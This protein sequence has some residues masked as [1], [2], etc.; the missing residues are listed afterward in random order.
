[1]HRG[2][3]CELST[4]RRLQIW[5]RQGGVRFTAAGQV[6]D[7]QKVAVDGGW[8]YTLEAPQGA[9]ALVATE[10]GATWRLP[11][12]DAAPSPKLQEARRLRSDRKLSQAKTL[13]RSIQDPAL[14]GGVQGLLGRIALAEGHTKA[15]LQSLE[16]SAAAHARAGRSSDE[17]RARFVLA[18]VFIEDREYASALRVLDPS[19]ACFK[20]NPEDVAGAHY[21]RGLI[22][23]ERGRV[24]PALRALERAQRLGQHLALTSI[25]QSARQT[26]A[27][28]LQQIGR[29]QEAWDIVQAL[30]PQ[31]QG[32]A[33]GHGLVNFAWSLLLA[34]EA[35]VPSTLVP[36]PIL[37]QALQAYL[38]ACPEPERLANVL[39]NRALAHIQAGD[40]VRARADL[41]QARGQLKGLSARLWAWVHDI[42]GRIALAEGRYRSAQDHFETLLENSSESD[43]RWRAG[44]GLAQ[45]LRALGNNESALRVLHQAESEVDRGL[46]WVSWGD[47]RGLFP[48]ARRKSAA[49]LIDL[50]ITMKRPGIA[51]TA[52]RKAR[53]RALRKQ[54]QGGRV[55]ALDPEAL[56]Y[57]SRALGLYRKSQQKLQDFDA[58]MW[59]VPQ[60]AKKQA[61]AER[62][63]LQAESEQAWNTAISLLTLPNLGDPSHLPDL[64]PQEVVLGYHSVPGGWVGFSKFRGRVRGRHLGPWPRSPQK[65]ADYL[66]KPFAE[67]I[68]QASQ[69]RLLTHAQTRAIDFHALTFD[70][71]PLIH[72]RPV[73]YA[74][75]L[76]P[77]STSSMMRALVVSDP[78]GD[79][80]AARQ[81]GLSVAQ[82]L[83]KGGWQVRHILGAEATNATLVAFLDKIDLLHYSG[84]SVFSGIEG[85]H[86]A[87][88][89]AGASTLTAGEILGLARVP[90]RVVLASCEGDAPTQRGGTAGL[91]LARTFVV[92]GASSVVAA[93]RE[94]PD[95]LAAEFVALM[96][97]SE[98]EVA[99][100]VAVQAA[101]RALL[102]R[103]PMAA[104]FRIYVR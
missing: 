31:L 6:V 99:G 30:L 13:L 100:Q 42:E 72:G 7:T 66:L 71:E 45:S 21:Y 50:A 92:A 68:R 90:G 62:H 19:L 81:E 4:D 52:F 58:E 3:K 89:L 61:Q 35:E 80:R 87:L 91:G 73:V 97:K 75:D 32:C 10:G 86:S 54:T 28:V 65:L 82:G 59:K 11:L 93:T 43:A 2:P 60:R 44:V 17:A 53:L 26:R 51:F 85:L 67:E 18:Y 39:V 64:P 57:W 96:Y 37:D 41:K 84:H 101:S 9:Q 33:R 56:G 12:M 8:R 20:D 16:A 27:E 88:A 22:D 47:G 48:D 36:L 40:S 1:M 15:A 78:R 74:L 25:V 55:E 46:R 34:R 24:G 14:L 103:D 83:S 49:L 98:G 5:G 79:L 94:V 76:P 102:Q 104:A 95:A 63:G 29:S 23:K 77:T 69:V 70:E 38:E